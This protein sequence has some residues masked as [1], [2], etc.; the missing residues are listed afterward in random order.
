[1]PKFFC[2]FTIASVNTFTVNRVFINDMS[3]MNN[4]KIITDTINKSAKP[5]ISVIFSSVESSINQ[6]TIK[7]YFLIAVILHI[8]CFSFTKGFFG[9]QIKIT[10]HWKT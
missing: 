8:L 5:H 1:M 10:V 7:E 4:I 2:Y 9:N 6:N 3:K